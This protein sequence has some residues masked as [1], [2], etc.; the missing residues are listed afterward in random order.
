[1]NVGL[2]IITICLSIFSTGVMSYIALATPIGPWIAPTL[3]LIGTFLVRAVGLRDKR[4][5]NGLALVTA[6][7][8][9]G[10]ILATALSFSFPTLY[11]LDKNVFGNWMAHPLS[12]VGLIAGLSLAGGSLGLFIADLLEHNLL[13]KQDLPFPIGQLVYKMIAAQNQTRKALELAW[14]ACV[15][16]IFTLLHGGTWFFK[17]LIPSAITLTKQH[18]LGPLAIPFVQIRFDVLPMLLAIGF[19]TGHVIAIPLIVGAV[20]RIGL[21]EP[22][23][24]LFFPAI[25]GSDFLLAF[26]SGLVAIGAVQSFFDLPKML[27]SWFRK[28]RDGK[29]SAMMDMEFFEPLQERSHMIQALL[30]LFLIIG[31]LSI[32]RFS[33]LSQMY[34]IVFSFICAYQIV[35]IAGEIGLAQLGRFATFVMVPALFLFGT[36][37]LQVTVIATFV[38]LSGGV[39]T[40]ILFGRKM[41]SMAG[42]SRSTIRWFQILGLIVSSISAGIVMWL[43]VHKFGLGNEPLVAQRAQARALLI[44]VTHFNWIVLIIGAIFGF[45]LKKCK[46]NPMLVLGGLLMP[47]PYSLGLIFGGCLSFTVKDRSEW[48]PFWSGVFAANS[49]TELAKTLI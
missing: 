29:P 17:A 22:I 25:S 12:F 35:V 8:S 16:L 1:M 20:G 39:A 45:V 42:I 26:G 11:F 48:E 31:Y 19:I 14:G 40:D 30:T 18:A 49:I 43:L 23:N 13:V 3:V 36:D 2:I 5:S 34:L 4:Y 38:E 9:I 33:A 28:M 6:G 44:N 10:G 47:L 41:S 21:M 15:T 24:K 37:P 27:K 32:L 7:G 46:L